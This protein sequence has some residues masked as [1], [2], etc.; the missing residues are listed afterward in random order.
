MAD[1]SG[2]GVES[3]DVRHQDR[4]EWRRNDSTGGTTKP[5]AHGLIACYLP[6]DFSRLNVDH[7]DGAGSILKHRVLSE[8]ADQLSV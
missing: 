1:R 5:A 3:P 7:A 2:V 8:R 6:F 4:A